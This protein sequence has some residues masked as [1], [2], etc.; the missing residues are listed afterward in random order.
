MEV[1][2]QLMISALITFLLYA[3]VPFIVAATRKKPISLKD[4]RIFTIVW[5]IICFLLKS[6]FERTIGGTGNSGV[7]W[8]FIW[9]GVISTNGKNILLARGVLIDGESDQ[10][11]SQTT[12]QTV[13][14]VYIEP[15][16]NEMGTLYSRPGYISQ[17]SED[18]F[19]QNTQ[20]E[21]Q[22]FYTQRLPSDNDKI[23]E[24]L[25]LKRLV[26]NNTISQEQY[27][28]ARKKLLGQ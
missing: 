10:T 11:P 13:Y 16:E 14:P 25:A 19:R 24:L 9:Y 8:P 27:E 6:G 26:D 5:V 4:W 18:K 23:N 2:L 1:F 3:V 22:V 17:N 12:E 7:I 21:Q 28:T 15:T 20:P